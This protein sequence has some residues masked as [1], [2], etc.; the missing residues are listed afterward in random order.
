MHHFEPSLVFW[1]LQVLCRTISFPSLSGSIP[2]ISCCVS[3]QELCPASLSLVKKAPILHH[4]HIL[5]P[6]PLPLFTLPCPSTRLKT[7]VK[8]LQ[9]AVICQCLLLKNSELW[10]ETFEAAYQPGNMV[11]I[12][13]VTH[14]INTGF[15]A[16]KRKRPWMGTQWLDLFL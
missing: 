7:Q 10:S 11:T 6:P 4:L 2:L 3:L 14:K 9:L 12:T 16:L 8:S 13:R 5:Y 1:S 15:P